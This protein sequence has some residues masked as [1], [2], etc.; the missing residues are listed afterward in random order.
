[1]TIEYTDGCMTTSILVDGEDFIDMTP[2]RDDELKNRLVGF[3]ESRTLSKEELQELLLWAVERYGN[4]EKQ[5]QCDTCGDD[6]F[7]TTLTI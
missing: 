4:A 3:V 1:M 2:E 7:T 6:V 5:Y